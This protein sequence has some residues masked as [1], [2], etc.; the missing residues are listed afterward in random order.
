MEIFTR[1]WSEISGGRF[2]AVSHKQSHLF[3]NSKYG[4]KKI[5]EIC[6]IN[7]SVNMSKFVMQ[8][9]NVSFIP[10]ELLSNDGKSF[11]MLSQNASL[12]KGF[13]RFQNDDLL[14]AKITPCMQNKKSA[15]VSGLE[16]GV[17]FGS[18]EF[19][20]L[21]T[22]NSNIVNIHFILQIL[23][24]DL[25]IEQ[26]KLNFKG[27]AGQ[28]RVPKDFL[29]NLLIPIPP[30]EIQE[31]IIDIMDNAYLLKNKKENEAKELLN[32]VDS[33]LLAE[34]GIELPSKD[35]SLEHRIYTTKLSHISGNRFDC[36]YHQSYYKTLEEAIQK[37]K[38]QTEKIQD[39]VFVNQQLEYMEKYNFINYI[40]LS[41]I[42][43]ENGIIKDT[44]LINLNFPSRARQKVHKGDLLVSTL[45]GSMKAI[46]LIEEYKENL[47]ASTGFFVINKV[48]NISK[49]FLISVLRTDLFQIL[50]KR[51]ASGSIMSSINYNDF[52]NLKIPLPPLSVQEKIANEITKRKQKA[53]NLQ[54][55]AKECLN[56]AKIQV[57]KIILGQQQKDERV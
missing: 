2:D 6:E 28:Q 4:L 5:K 52:L 36:E 39:S 54:K 9:K 43:K 19:F 47:I 8:G 31:Q 34:L 22:K 51:K 18:T 35:I 55:E 33:Y 50:L 53:L 56:S 37:G 41:C 26:A 12:Y 13:T 49:D 10:M 25:V 30:K 45:S 21:R 27:S 42:D 15:V 23:R 20:V 17:G 3:A 48:K 57:E 32:S 40:D 11:T 46:A 38:Y 24:M 14:W 16:N 1:K 29:E 7:P 44:I